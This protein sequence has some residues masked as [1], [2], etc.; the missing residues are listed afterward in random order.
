M[1]QTPSELLPDEIIDEINRAFDGVTREGGVSFH[2]ADVID[3]YGSKQE[4]TKARKLDTDEC[5]QDV[6]E[7][8]I[9]NDCILSFLDPIG[10]R[11][12]M[13]AYTKPN[14]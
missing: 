6:P 7:K 3:N 11:Y 12:Y 9:E 5:W 10:F 4:R 1:T 14:K 8:D 13:A 2:E